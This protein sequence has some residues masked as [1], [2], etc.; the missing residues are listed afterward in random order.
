MT[1]GKKTQGKGTSDVKQM[2]KCLCANVISSL[3][4]ESSELQTTAAHL[5]DPVDV[6][7]STHLGMLLS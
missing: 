1:F 3:S 7:F 6:K 5:Q 2:L 4:K